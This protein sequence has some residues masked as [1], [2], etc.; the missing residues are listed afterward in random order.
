M[1]RLLLTTV[2][3]VIVLISD[4]QQTVGL[5]TYEQSS[6]D[7][8]LLFAPITSVNTY[9]IDKCGYQVHQWTSSH[10]VGQ[11]VYLLEDGTLLRPG[12]AGNPVFTAGGNGGV[13]EKFDWDS[14]LLWSFD[15]SDSLQCQHHDICPL[16]NGNVLAVAWEL[17]TVDEASA[18]GRNP[19]LLGTSLWSEKVVELQQVGEDGANIVWEW[20]VWD[21]LVQDFDADA[22]NFGIVADNPQLINLNFVTGNATQSDWLHCNA[23]DY[24]EE[25]DQ[26]MISCHNMSE[27]WIID[28]STTSTEAATHSGGNHNMGG[29]L[30][31][32]WGN[33]QAYDRG[34]AMDKKLFGQ[35]NPTWI[36]NGLPGDG[37]ILVFNNGVQRPEGVFSTVET[38]TPPMDLDGNYDLEAD[39]AYLPF[40]SN[41]IYSAPTP[42]D[43]FSQ[44]I[45]GAQRLGNGNTLVCE[46]LS[47]NFFELDSND[48]IVWRYV[49]PV[50]QNGAVAQGINPAMN[51]V[52]RCTLLEE[53]Y[54]GL[55]GQ[56]LSPGLPIELNPL[57][58]DCSG[59]GGIDEV[60]TEERAVLFATIINQH[61]VI[62]TDRELKDSDLSI[63]DLQGR[64]IY[65]EYQRFIAA[66]VS[67][68][69]PLNCSLSP[70]IYLVKIET[71]NEKLEA[72]VCSVFVE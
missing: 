64:V 57:D 41:W 69:I 4:A 19:A 13:I 58:Y 38:F 48:N 20:H 23:I 6:Q 26:I 28:H 22:P 17:K 36:T 2:F 15:I 72:Q 14:N 66:N 62:K 21:H 35:H 7:G 5:F 65:C 40:G 39:Q 47:G 42:E 32:R 34:T 12:K 53:D 46:G 45:S 31:Y 18:A 54:P 10:T 68:T 37:D 24:N 60:Q 33:P 51:M 8:F 27:I 70:G 56:N 49:N 55:D 43:F 3:S 16:P 30:L 59:V 63:Y 67:N 61:L 71:A 25:L 44:A 50:G 52:F 11:S 9:L 29:D 1:N